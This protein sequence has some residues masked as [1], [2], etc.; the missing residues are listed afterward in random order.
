MVQEY[1]DNII[2]PPSQFQDRPIPALRRKNQ[3]VPIPRIEIKE[4]K[5][6]LNGF[7]KSNEISLRSN[8]DPLIQLQNTRLAVSHFFW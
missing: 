8:R 6:A 4:K 2:P 5:T 3:P 7:N 1:E